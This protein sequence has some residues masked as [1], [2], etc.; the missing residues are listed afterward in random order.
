LRG[1]KSAKPSADD[2]D[3]L[4]LLHEDTA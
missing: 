1:G 2:H 3:L 4:T